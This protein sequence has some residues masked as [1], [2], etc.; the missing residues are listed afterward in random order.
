[1]TTVSTIAFDPKEL[2]AKVK[3]MYRDVAENPHG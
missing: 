1:M 2:E 3:S